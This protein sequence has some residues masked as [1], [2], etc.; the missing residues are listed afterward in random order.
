M[1]KAII[2]NLMQTFNIYENVTKPTVFSSTT[3]NQWFEN[4]KNS[5]H[6]S[7]INAAR[8]GKVDYNQTKLS[9]PAITY[10][11][12]YSKYKKDTNVSNS[13][14]L[15]YV[16]I[17]SPEFDILSIDNSKVYAYYKSFGGLGYSII[18]RVKNLSLTNFKSTYKHII[19]D[20]DISNFVDI[21]AA[22]ASQFNVLSYDPNLFINPNSFIYSSTTIKENTPQSD[23]IIKKEKAYTLDGGVKYKSVRYNNLD[24]ID[25][26]GDYIVNWEGYDF[27]NCFI[28][29]KK[30]DNNK[31]NFLLSY[32][33]N[34]VFLNPSLD[35]ERVF[36]ILNNVNQIACNKPVNPDQLYRVIN[37]VFKYLKEGTLKPIYFNKKRKIVFNQKSKLTKEEKLN[38]C[39]K[40]FAIKRTSDSKLKLYN[41]IENWDS[42]HGKISQAKIYNNH[43]ISKKTVEKYWF[44]YKALVND[45][46]KMPKV[47]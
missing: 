12:T 20:L 35:K 44:E 19:E 46:N 22:K 41:I 36:N 26:E 25:I 4:I 39:L 33:N 13:T 32:C 9:L 3:I 1:S 7:S 43:P 37:S 10:N 6:T 34:L 5:S 31:N 16:D 42:L 47:A 24:E 17:D 27:I 14:G 8:L 11:F 28:P 15:L 30:I 18:V 23:V 2:N 38:I 45:L 21:N 29:I 40:E